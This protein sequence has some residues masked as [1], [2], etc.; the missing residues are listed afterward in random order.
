VYNA[1]DGDSGALNLGGS[2]SLQY[3]NTVKGAWAD[4][5]DNILWLQPATDTPTAGG[6]ASKTTVGTLAHR[7]KRTHSLREARPKSMH[8]PKTQ[9]VEKVAY[10]SNVDNRM[11]TSD[12]VPTR[13][14]IWP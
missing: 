8:N 14:R 13:K 1:D 10:L 2:F 11:T 3:A 6:T 5:V 7:A 4:I 9:A 12:S